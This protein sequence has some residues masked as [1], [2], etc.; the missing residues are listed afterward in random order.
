MKKIIALVL[1]LV[2]TVAASVAG[3]VA[4]LQAE[5]SDVN[6]MTLGNVK[7]EQ[8]EQER[9][10][11][12]TL[13]DF[14]QGQPA[15]P[16]VGPIDWASKGVD[17]NGTEYLVFTEKLQ[18]VIDKIVTVE[19]VGKSDAFVR[20]IIALEAPGYDAKNLIHVNVNPDGITQTA[21]TPVDINGVEYVY[22]VFTYKAAL[23]AGEGSAP[24]L[25]QVFLDSKATNED[26]A[27]FGDV[28]DIRVLS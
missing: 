28:W 18:N 25:V 22:S 17:V 20:T 24:S 19:N 10:E 3:T 11:D 9:A 1:A 7:I 13:Q 5:D 8:I 4:Y 23:K 16:A 21:W 14:T 15:Y 2:L 26:V 12:G 27:K 6:V